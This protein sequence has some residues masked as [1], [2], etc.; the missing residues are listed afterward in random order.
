MQKNTI[1]KNMY[2]FL[3][4][5]INFMRS[6]TGRANVHTVLLINSGQ[7]MIRLSGIPPA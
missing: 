5:N 4:N 2:L 1:A 7:R 6:L 3:I